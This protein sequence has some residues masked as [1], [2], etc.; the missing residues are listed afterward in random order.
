LNWHT[1]TCTLR[2]LLVITPL[3]DVFATT[4]IAMIALR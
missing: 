4:F 2:D 1:N 3:I